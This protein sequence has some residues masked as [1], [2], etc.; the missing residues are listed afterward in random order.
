MPSELVFGFETEWMN[1][2][3]GAE[4]EVVARCTLEALEQRELHL[5]FHGGNGIFLENSS[6]C[7][8]D[9]G[10][11]ETCTPEVSSPLDLVAAVKAMERILVDISQSASRLLGATAA[12]QFGRANVDRSSAATYG[13]HESILTAHP[14]DFYVKYLVPFLVTRPVWSGA[15]GLAPGFFG[16]TF[17]VAPRLLLFSSV[18]CN[19]S[20]SSR[21]IVNLRDEP[22]AKSGNHRLHIIAGETN[23]SELCL[24]L[25]AGVTALV[26]RAADLGARIGLE[27]F[28]PVKSMHAVALDPGCKETLPLSDGRQLT[29]VQIQFEYLALVEKY[30]PDLPA[31]APALCRRWRHVLNALAEDPMLLGRTLD[32]PIKYNI[33]KAQ[34]KKI[35]LHPDGKDLMAELREAAGNT[36]YRNTAP[37]LELLLGPSSPILR[38]VAELNAILRRR[39]LKWTQLKSPADDRARLSEILDV[40]FGILGEGLF[41][42]MDR[43]GVLEHRVLGDE[44]IKRARKEAPPGTRACLRSQ[45]IKE[46]AG[47]SDAACS[48]ECVVDKERGV[49]D[50][51]DP[52]E[53]SARWHAI[54]IPKSEMQAQIA[55]LRRVWEGLQ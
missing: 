11:L 22:L 43:Q 13:Q 17:A 7:Y 15:G 24:Y 6:R 25:K 37:S 16:V 50:L 2:S 1:F 49:L 54:D 44:P 36:A 41:D 27:I 40:R 51:S 45:A 30:L 31:W 52:R 4:P 3:A 48:W 35:D 9:C 8:V 14:A 47:R 33:W 38:K 19:E 42:V 20:T 39:G 21:P 12:I 53:R 26:V 32:W 46:L 55:E 5:P 28:D 34:V 10:H 23:A 18:A 29:A